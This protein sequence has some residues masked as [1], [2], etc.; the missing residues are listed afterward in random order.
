MA[1]DRP[2]R[3]AGGRKVEPAPPYVRSAPEPPEWLPAEALAEWRRVVPEM[4]RLRMLKKADRAALTAYVCTWDRLVQ[5]QAMV[6]TE[7]VLAINSQGRVRHPA[8]AIVEAAAKELRAWA[9]EFGLT[10]TAE[11]RMQLPPVDDDLDDDGLLDPI[12]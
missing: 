5:A 6:N 8:V 9:Q 3:D 2:G 11:G 12:V 1:G 10:P 4:Q 7:G